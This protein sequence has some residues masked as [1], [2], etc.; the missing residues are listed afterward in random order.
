MTSSPE[1]DARTEAILAPIDVSIAKA[2]HA[3]LVL[4]GRAKGRT[5][6]R[7]RK[8]ARNLLEACGLIPYES[9]SRSTSPPAGCANTIVNYTRPGS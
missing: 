9:H 7:R 2:R 3:A 5:H 6:A 1:H 8:D 4:T